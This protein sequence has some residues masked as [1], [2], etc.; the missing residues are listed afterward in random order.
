MHTDGD[1][2]PISALQ[3]AMFCARQCALIHV[4]QTWSE[5]R[6]TAEGKVLHERVHETE[7]ETRSGVRI[8]RGLRLRSLELGLTGIADVVE[9][10]EAA[11]GVS[12]PGRCGLWRAYP[13]E[14]KR[15]RRKIADC[16]R[17]QLCAQAL[18]LEEMLACHIPEGAL[19]YGEPRRREVV[20]LT[21]ELRQATA[22]A[23]RRAQAIIASD[24][25]PPPTPGPYCRT[26]SLADTCLPQTAGQPGRVARYLE[27][28][29]AE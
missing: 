29:L 19:F 3:H 1:L 18:C 21:E 27:R 11:D 10:H 15:G 25:L 24:A 5:N 7:S 4:D 23:A 12:V 6:F 28:V 9:F 22:E 2:I 20:P 8:A 16:D 13:V 14:Y 17:I 26:C